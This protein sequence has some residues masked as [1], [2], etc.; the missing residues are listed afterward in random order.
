MATPAED[1]VQEQDA[2][3]ER[4]L[5]V[6]TAAIE[7]ALAL[8]PFDVPPPPPGVE[9][10]VKLAIIATLISML[11]SASRRRGT[12]STPAEQAEVE[13]LAEKLTPPVVDEAWQWA[14]EYARS[15]DEAGTKSGVTPA[16]RAS[17]SKALARTLATRAT[18]ESA[19]ALA[20]TISMPF[21]V[22]I[23]RG[24][25]GVRSTHR[26]LHGHPV[27]MDK[28]FRVW[29]NGQVLDFPGD[30]RAPI[31]ETANCRC[32]LIFAETEEGVADA[33]APADL[34]KAFALAAS[35][36]ARW[37]FDD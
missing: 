5:P 2:S 6:A 8:P 7:A 30:P 16:Q 3:V 4:L 15:L 22:W 35:L 13:P 32:L 11:S 14:V 18:A 37:G 27:P 12:P 26:T 24:D 33:L 34:D 19:L 28:P 23:S 29:P 36:D 9:A 1:A 17:R 21:K 25:G 31:R 20:H 10:G